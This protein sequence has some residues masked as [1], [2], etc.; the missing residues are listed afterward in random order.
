MDEFIVFDTET[1]ADEIQRFT[2]GCFRY[3]VRYKNQY[4]V[5][6]EGLIYADDLPES[7]PG[8][9][10][11]L[12][13]YVAF[14]DANVDMRFTGPREPS[15][16]LLLLSRSQFA[17][18]WLWDVAYKR[19]A[20]LIGFNLPFDLSRLALSVTEARAPFLDGFSFQ[21]FKYN[22]RPNLR[23][24]HI[25]NK[26]S[27]IGWSVSLL[28]GPK[29][30]GRFIDLRTATF[31]LT[32]V[33]HTLDSA[34]KTFG[35]D[36]Q[37]YAAQEHGVINADYISYCR[38]D[39][40][41]TAELFYKVTEEYERHPISTPLHKVFSPASLAKSYYTAMG[42]TPPLE[43]FT[44]GDD[45]YGKVM[46][47]FYGARTECRIRR[48]KTPVTLVDFTSM[49]PTVNA[50]MQLW[51]L[52][53]SNDVEAWDNT[54]SVR[55]LIDDLTIED[56]FEFPKTIWPR[57]VG[58]AR[59]RPNEDILP[60]RAKYGADSTYN[61]GINYLTYDGD[62]WYAIPDLVASKILTGKSPEILEAISFAEGVHGDTLKP[63]EL[64]GDITIDPSGDDFFRWVI[65]ERARVKTSN[66]TLAEFL[67]VLA[68][69][70][71]Y[72]IFAEM[73]R[74]DSE[75]TVD[76]FSAPDTP[77]R[78]KV[79]HPERPGKYAFPP[80]AACITAAAR[81]MLAMLEKCVVDA[82]GSWVFCD[83]DSMA[84]VSG[85]TEFPSLPADVV[86]TIIERFDLLS[87]YDR[88]LIPHILKKE[89][90]GWC[91][92]ISSKR[93][94]LFDDTNTIRK[95]SEHGLGHL[96]GPDRDWKLWLWNVVIFGDSDDDSW[97]DQAALSQWSVST[98]R[99]YRT[100]E[101]WN[102]GKPYRDQIKPFNF[103]S[104]AYIRKEHR[105]MLQPGV[106]GI[107]LITGYVGDKD[108]HTVEWINKYDP[109]GPVYA[110]SSDVPTFNLFEEL[111]I[112]KVLTYRDVLADYRI[113]PEVKFADVEGQTCG[114][115][116]TGQ[117]YRH[118]VHLAGVDFIGKE[119]N[120]VDEVQQGLFDASDLQQ[121][122]TPADLK[123]DQVRETVF[124]LLD[125]YTATE[126]ARLADI[127]RSEYGRL[128]SGENRPHRKVREI[129]IAM[130]VRIACEDL[131]RSPKLIK[132]SRT[133]F[134]EWRLKYG[135]E[136]TRAK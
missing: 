1:T 75:A 29:N 116:T 9:Y 76:M 25:D 70:G 106:K 54:D 51:P 133:V 30:R 82:G 115:H 12:H 98:P 69:S 134:A 43:K 78:T 36:T 132:D 117:L 121:E 47:A 32:N 71:S 33:P 113:H 46:S 50:L 90:V 83:T 27:F 17:E 61:I 93:Y 109:D 119:S 31:A 65:E 13:R 99:L 40:A 58:I 39:V 5:L 41:T 118:H 124:A 44:I 88:E 97:L 21:L 123:W 125:R 2:F 24:K 79:R 53:T 102:A 92:A 4:S 120:K 86:D 126:N 122:A 135:Y 112:V 85:T 59:I 11:S 19:D 73:V 28:D 114:L 20:T 22:M 35:C 81:L 45:V 128:R 7:N 63:V 18:R 89:F 48:V 66:P 68:N 96:K 64:R 26:K 52:L 129:L 95:L 111:T 56:L 77:W 42:I 136:A 34:A 100:L 67:K 130:A 3:V 91:Y 131:G 49:Y 16:H 38:N 10:E 8:G 62:L 15:W 127:S 74:D 37:K 84:I 6:A 60:V 72:G 110:V 23:I 108:P 57:F 107:Q 104:A 105:P 80:I 14:N 103:L 55:E 87:P 101:R 94:A